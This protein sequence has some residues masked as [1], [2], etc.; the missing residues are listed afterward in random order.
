MLGVIYS[1]LGTGKKVEVW[2]GVGPEHLEMWLRKNTWPTPSL[3]N[4]NDMTELPLRQGW[5]LHDP[6][7]S[8]KTWIFGFLLII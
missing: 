3:R 2:G 6:P 5:K 1:I 4:K 7:T 8:I